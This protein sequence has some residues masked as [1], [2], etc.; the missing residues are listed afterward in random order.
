MENIQ[1]NSIQ[2]LQELCQKLLNFTEINDFLHI[3]I[4]F[5]EI[6]CIFI[7]KSTTKLYF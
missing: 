2:K 7:E 4:I 5:N 3:A 6:I 1:Q